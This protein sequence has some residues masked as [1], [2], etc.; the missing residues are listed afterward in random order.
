MI[1][2]DVLSPG[3]WTR[4]SDVDWWELQAREE[5]EAESDERANALSRQ[6]HGG[7]TEESAF[8]NHSNDSAAAEQRRE[9]LGRKLKRLG[10]GHALTCA[11]LKLWTSMVCSTI[12]SRL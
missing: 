9:R 8:S 1:D 2:I 12:D 7:S 6:Q 11:S 3:V 5:A 4:A 10:K